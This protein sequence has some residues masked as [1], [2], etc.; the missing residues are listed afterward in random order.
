MSIKLLLNDQDITD[1]TSKV[2]WSGQDEQV[3]RTI[4]FETTSTPFD[5][6]YSAP[7]VD[8]GDTVMF[9]VDGKL[10]FEGRVMNITKKNEVGTVEFT[11]NDYLYNLVQSSATYSFKNKSPEFICR[12]VCKDFGITVAKVPKTNYKIKKYIPSQMSPYNIIM[13]AFQKAEKK[14][15]KKYMIYMKGSDLKVITKGTLIDYEISGDSNMETA[16]YTKDATQVINRVAVYNAKGQKIGTYSTKSSMAKY[17][18]MQGAVNVDKGKGKT[19]AKNTLKNAEETAS[20]TCTG[21]ARCIS[22]YAISIDDESTNLTGKYYI[23]SDTHEFEN[24]IYTMTLE[25]TKKNEDEDIS[26]EKIDENANKVTNA[27]GSVTKTTTKKYKATFTAYDEHTGKGKDCKGHKLNASKHTCAM[28]KSIAKYGSKITV[29]IKGSPIDGNSYK[30]TDVPKHARLNGKVHVDILFK[31]K[32][33]AKAFGIKTGTVKVVT[34][35]VIVS[36]GDGKGDATGKKIVEKAES[37]KGCKYVWG[38]SGPST[39]DC[40]GLVWWSCHNAGVKFSRTDTK[41][42]S[43]L[44]TK[45]AYS[46]MEIGDIIL[47][48][49]N[50]GYGGIHHTGI[51]I[52]DGKMIHAPHSGDVVKESSITSGYYRKQFYTARRIR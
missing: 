49:S 41:G 26:Y 23:K 11:A 19:E 36:A 20:V 45:V 39:F 31:T 14:N 17:G 24:G 51:Y 4:A 27:D 38:A 13:K 40:S 46:D 34:K 12:S 30:V 42:L 15:K 6:A 28:A 5:S 7:D 9:Y 16:E 3:T 37:K 2:T 50:G 33:E 21:D 52:G 18:I 35:T 44:G 1:I 25:L 8:G 22:G 47:F 43:K 29:S 10:K 48:S 32:A